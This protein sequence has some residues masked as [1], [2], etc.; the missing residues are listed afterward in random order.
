MTSPLK[1]HIFI[2]VCLWDEVNSLSE[3]ELHVQFS[4]QTI[5]STAHRVNP[6]T[7]Q[8]ELWN[9]METRQPLMF[10]LRRLNEISAPCLE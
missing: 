4:S 6:Y 10:R 3:L 9:L 5:Y 2:G 8:R 7:G 1:R